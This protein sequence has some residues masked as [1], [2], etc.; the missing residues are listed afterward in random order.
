[1]TRIRDLIVH[2]AMHGLLV[3]AAGDTKN[4]DI[5]VIGFRIDP[6]VVRFSDGP[7]RSPFTPRRVVSLLKSQTQNKNKRC[8]LPNTIANVFVC[9]TDAAVVNTGAQ[10]FHAL[11]DDTEQDV[12][13]RSTDDNNEWHGCTCI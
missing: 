7:Q 11:D 3:C 10:G 9:A 1:M 2:H 6:I 12:D 13:L 8:V 5:V 4:T